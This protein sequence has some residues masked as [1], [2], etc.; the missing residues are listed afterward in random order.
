M[1]GGIIAGIAMEGIVKNAI[2]PESSQLRILSIPNDV[3]AGKITNIRFITFNEGGAV[4]N[5]NVTLEGAA[6]ERSR[7]DGEGLLM[8]AANVTSNGT[9]KVTG[10]KSGYRNAT[11][12][13]RATPGLDI[14]ASPI[15]I[16]SG[17][18]TYVTFLV[19]SLGR[20][21]DNVTIN[22]TGAGIALEGF[23]NSKGQVVMDVD[24]PATGAITVK[25][26]KA[27]YAEISTTITSTAQ[28]I[29]GVSSNLQVFTVDV[30]AYA[31]FT[32]TA[33]GSPVNDAKVSLSGV[34]QGSGTTNQEGK[35]VILVT[36][37]TTGMITVYANATGYAGGSTTL[38]SSS[39]QSL[40]ISLS[41]TTVTAGVPTYVRFTLMNGNNP[42]SG[43]NVTLSGTA[44]GNG[45]TNQ[46]GEAIILVNSTGAG[47]ITAS[48]SR[49]GYSGASAT[50]IS[51]GQPGLGISANPSNITNGVPTYVTF[52]V[53]SGGSG[54]SG[55]TVS[56]TGG[57]ISSDGMTNSA[58]QVTLQLNSA[59]AGTIS[60]VARKSGYIDGSTTLSH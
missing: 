20:P 49:S 30:P 34:A 31:T 4:G 38:T 21:V 25:A 41:P 8:L 16:T 48:G 51:A 58:G 5:V 12:F 2:W 39:T 36:P 52:T 15:S 7:T 23:T 59:G 57:G 17:T 42:I 56:V 29:L 45:I 13:I 43:A 27:G 19:T 14:S 54:I 35:T 10:E 40:Y 11:F 26:R 33:G 44:G 28:Q 18:A 22:L 46:N 53:T 32:V 6:S 1:I 37:R 47:T 9:I 60:A 3:G 24:T 50:L 55:A